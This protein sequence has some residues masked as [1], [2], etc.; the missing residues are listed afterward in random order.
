MASGTVADDSPL[1]GVDVA[2][3]GLTASDVEEQR[4]RIDQ[5][6]SASG[7][8]RKARGSFW[9]VTIVA[10]ALAIYAMYT[11]T[12]GSLKLQTTGRDITQLD[13]DHG[14]DQDDGENHD[15]DAAATLAAEADS[16]PEGVTVTDYIFKSTTSPKPQTTTRPTKARAAIAKRAAK[17][18]AKAA[19]KAGG[20][21]PGYLH[22]A[23][24]KTTCTNTF[25]WVNGYPCRTEGHTEEEGCYPRGWSCM[26]YRKKGWCTDGVAN[27]KKFS[28]AFFDTDHGANKHEALNDPTLNCCECGK[29]AGVLGEAPGGNG[30]GRP[31]S[32]CHDGADCM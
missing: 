20:K 29:P 24:A 3:E 14:G 12:H 11:H 13:S 10:S 6:Q 28:W 17:A 15:K 5:E 21:S 32:E 2:S 4:R 7:V 23:P 27:K 31:N 1:V 26:A 30:P 19:A 22:D 9:A 25:G 8:W 18:P 16:F